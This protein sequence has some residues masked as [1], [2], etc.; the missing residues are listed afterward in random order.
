M[1]IYGLTPEDAVIRTAVHNMAGGA[2]AEDSVR[3]SR[4]RTL[5]CTCGTG[6]GLRLSPHI[7]ARRVRQ[8]RQ[9]VQ[10]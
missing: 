6:P 10:A 2:E 3:L 4:H 9:D 8:D 5:S 1:S 7:G